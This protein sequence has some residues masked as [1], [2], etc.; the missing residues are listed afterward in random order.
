MGANYGS[1]QD[2]TLVDGVGGLT[3]GDI[4][5]TGFLNVT[6]T[7]GAIEQEEDSSIVVTG[8]TT[9]VASNGEEVPATAYDITLDGANDFNGLVNATGADITLNDIN[10]L[11]LGDIT[12]SGKL[13]A[14]AQDDLTLSGTINAD[15]LALEA[16]EGSISQ[17]GSSTLTV[18]TGPSDLNAAIDIT[19]DGAND[20]NGLVN[21][22]GTDIT[23]NDSNDLELGNIN[24]SGKLDVTAQND[25]ALSGEINADTLALEA[26]DGSISQG[27]DSTLTV[28]SGPSD[29]IAAGDI[30]LDGN[31]D[32]KGLVN[33]TGADITL[34]DINA[35]ELGD[36]TASGKLDATAQN[37]LALNNEIN[38]D[39]LALKAKNGSI[40]QGENST[41]M[42]VSGPSDLTAKGNITLDGA[43][44]FNGLVNA[45][46]ADITLND[47]NDLEPVNINASGNAK[48]D[49]GGALAAD[50]NVTGNSTLTSVDT[51]TVSGNSQN[52]TTTTTGTNSSTSFG[53]TTVRGDL[54]TTTNNGNI[55]QTEPLRVASATSLTAGT[56][57]IVLNN[58]NNRFSGLLKVNSANSV[59]LTGIASTEDRLSTL[60][61]EPGAFVSGASDSFSPAPILDS[62]I[63]SSPSPMS[64]DGSS[65]TIFNSDGST[66]T[67]SLSADGIVTTTTETS[68][69]NSTSRSERLDLDALPVNIL[70]LSLSLIQLGVGNSLLLDEVRN[71]FPDIVAILSVFGQDG[72]PLSA[73]IS[74]D[75]NTGVL[76]VNDWAN[77]HSEEAPVYVLAVD[78][79]GELL[80]FRLRKEPEE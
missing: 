6:S 30:S 26:E 76:S 66:I 31:N 42:V 54:S 37:D 24:A 44:D 35:L 61:V 67:V 75:Q 2:I 5:T 53:D 40:S 57:D 15:S 3:L 19:L 7:N 41:L 18:I 68:D 50:L 71:D 55:T 38:A 20:F 79:M 28:V 49:A 25:L 4:S 16:K 17:G 64:Q 59:L 46:G 48:L 14:T 69:G 29:L 13:D 65:T 33:A 23:L 62:G 80:I 52:L 1:W 56:G 8:A 77:W 63:G 72:S 70:E 78:R 32:F 36:I 39:S 27:E 58:A 74:Y 34:N 12:A 73:G 10:V 43:N 21:A 11:D 60:H 47:I 51:M 9:L 22:S 45:T